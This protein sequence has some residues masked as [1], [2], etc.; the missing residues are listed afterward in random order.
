VVLIVALACVVVALLVLL[1][2]VPH[3][4]ERIIAIVRAFRE[5]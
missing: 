3:M 1:A 5:K 4:S 2:F